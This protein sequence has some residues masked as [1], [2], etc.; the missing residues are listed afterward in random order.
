[1]CSQCAQVGEEGE[2][3]GDTETSTK[4]SD[5]ST[6]LLK[7]PTA[8]EHWNLFLDYNMTKILKLHVCSMCISC[9]FQ[10]IFHRLAGAVLFIKVHNC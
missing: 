7:G 2:R 5:S 4:I 6:K 1:M 3:E 9:S 8:S 10:S